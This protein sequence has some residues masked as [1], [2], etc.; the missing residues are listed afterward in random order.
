MIER[1]VCPVLVGREDEL[2]LLED[3]LIDVGTGEGRVVVLA[4]EAGLGKTRL[5]SELGRH[6]SRLGCTVLWG[7]CAEAD[8]AVPYLPFLEAIGNSLARADLAALRSR[9]GSNVRDLAR[10]FPQ[11]GTEPTTPVAGEDQVQAKLRLF[12]AILALLGAIAAGRRLLLVVEDLHWADASTHELLDY[13]ARRIATLPILLLVTCRIEEVD[14]RHPVHPTL[15]H[16]RRARLVPTIRLGSLR[17]DHV[18][19]IVGAIF[20]QPQVGA[21]FR[22]YMHHRSEGN[23]FVLEEMLKEAL[24]NG[25]IF[26]SDA[27][28]ERRAIADLRIPRSVRDAILARLER[29]DATRREVLRTAAVIGPS[30]DFD[31]LA[32][33]CGLDTDAL[34]EAMRDCVRLQLVEEVD[35]RPRS[36]RF[37]HSLTWEAI[38]RDIGSPRRRRL[39]ERLAGALNERHAAAAERAYHLTG[40]GRAAEAVPLWIAAA[41]EALRSHAY[42]GAAELYQR[43]LPHIDDP[44]RRAHVHGAAG[45]ALSFAESSHVPAAIHHLEAC[46]RT[47]E[48]YDAHRAAAG[49]RVILGRCY[50]LMGDRWAARAEYEAARA[51]LEPFGAS[52]DLANVY[53]RLGGLEDFDCHWEA[54][55]PLLRKAIEIAAQASADAPRISASIMLAGAMPDVG[56]ADEAA[57]LCEQAYEE[58]TE[59]GLVLLAGNALGN[60]VF[61]LLDLLRARECPAVVERMRT[62][63][64]NSFSARAL[65]ADGAASI[66]L[67]RLEHAAQVLRAHASAVLM[68]GREQREGG[69]YLAWALSELGLRDEA[70]RYTIEPNPEGD[71]QEIVFET[72]LWARCHLAQGTPTAALPAVDRLLRRFDGLPPWRVHGPPELSDAVTAVLL[73]AGD[74]E[75]ACAVSAQAEAHGLTW[76]PWGKRARARCLLGTGDVAA[77]QSLLDEVLAEFVAAEYRLAATETRLLLAR[78]LLANGDTSDAVLQADEAFARATECSAR[79]LAASAAGLLDELGV[80]VSSAAVG[81]ATGTRPRQPESLAQ[82]EVVVLRSHVAASE[83]AMA[84][85]A[86][87]VARLQR[88]A[89]G[90]IHDRRG[91][92]LDATSD[93]LTA[94]FDGA[95]DLA[96][97]C[98]DAYQT[99]QAILDKAVFLGVRAGAT[100]ALGADAVVEPVE[101][102]LRVGDQVQ[103][104]LLPWLQNHRPLAAARSTDDP[105][106]RGGTDAAANTFRRDGEYWTISYCSAVVRLRDSKGLRDLAILVSQPRREV[107]AVDLMSTSV[108]AAPAAAGHAGARAGLGAEGDLGPA[109]DDHATRQYR[110]RLVDLDVEIDAA[111]L[112]NDPERAAR[113][114][115]ERE[116]L[117][118]QLRAA[119][120]LGGRSRRMLDPAERARKAVT[121]RI[122]DAI[123]RIAATDPEIGDHLRRSVRTGAFCVYDPAEPTVWTT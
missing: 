7:S 14:R 25:D 27:G 44:V 71:N 35:E 36:L 70:M 60:E 28:W 77:A 88:W 112:D 21:E 54:S 38:Y 19:A 118:D 58:A 47:L 51:A 16:W 34:D 32:A 48:S 65:M 115:D 40:A 82:R 68:G 87:G 72:L 24:D 120:G 43:A 62:L 20:G 89:R 81:H 102:V 17:P 13:I 74:A 92:V 73:A 4:G 18:A 106:L 3:A 80:A 97:R 83:H 105:A 86:D 12:E 33:M 45:K 116:F 59:H 56:E 78:T 108:G 122:R 117:L 15:Q 63:P 110:A 111:E 57:P 41:E 100:V 99:G 61:V 53:S 96:A 2:S 103:T 29:L 8:L 121:G 67:G 109:L 11:F 93:R 123:A 91:V 5:A 46:V 85:R 95:T 22:D 84:G 37:R 55:V 26:R 1:A 75:R 90:R 42:A 10:M 30:F 69:K 94:A 23:P 64:A 98:V 119:V 31:T 76:S 107:A 104:L 6:A 66:Y 101:G 49:H 39:H 114:R 113:A 9:L 52:E 79:Q 50:W